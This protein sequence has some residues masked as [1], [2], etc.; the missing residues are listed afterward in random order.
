MST[1]YKDLKR[2]AH[3]CGAV[4]F[5]ESDGVLNQDIVLREYADTP[6][7]L[8]A[9]HLTLS[10]AV[11]QGAT[12]WADEQVAEFLAGHGNPKG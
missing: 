5:S 12:G 11:V 1:E 10:K 9:K 3:S 2:K 7:E 4:L 6:E 8:V